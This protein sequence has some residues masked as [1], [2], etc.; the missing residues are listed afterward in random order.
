MQL[1]ELQRAF[2]ARI[3]SLETGIEAQL[4]DAQHAD[5]GARLDAYVG[6]YRA[7]LIEAL[8]TTYPV[9]KVTLGDDEFD[10]QMRLYIDSIP[11]QHYSVRHYGAGI[12]QHIATQEPGE[13]GLALSELAL[14][15]WTLADVF[16]ASDEASLD[17]ATLATVPPAAWPTV[18]FTLG[19]TIRRLETRTNVVEWWR[20]ENGLCERPN[21]LVLAAPAH[22]LLWRR[23]IK[24]LFRSLDPTEAAALTD[25]GN[26]ATFGTLC[27][28]LAHDV[29]E[30]NVALRAA[31][32]LRGWIA[33]ELIVRCSWQDTEQ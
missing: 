5:F 33:E 13:L 31:S 7:R 19:A 29:E 16:D 10:R 15:E 4:K 6:G 17:V 22:W 28:G 3:L 32:L 2:Q 25:A 20:A 8:G 1:Q 30:A 18:S 12:A 11:S 9:L 23:G 27:E 14:W 21:A 24:T 26:G